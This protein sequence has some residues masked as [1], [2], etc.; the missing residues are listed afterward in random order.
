M[1][2]H[3]YPRRSLTIT[4]VVPLMRSKRLRNPKTL[5]KGETMRCDFGLMDIFENLFPSL[6]AGGNLYGGELPHSA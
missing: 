4:H 5:T 6:F 3:I 2:E 1:R